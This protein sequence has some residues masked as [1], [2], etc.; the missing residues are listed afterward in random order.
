MKVHYLEIVTHDV[1]GQCAALEAAS[2]KP[3]SEPVASLGNARIAPLAPNG[4]VGVRAPMSEEEQPTIRPYVLTSDIEAALKAAVSAGGEI[5]H[6]P[7]EIP[8]EGTFAIY[9]LDGNQHGL[10]Q[11]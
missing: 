11:L 9:F 8:G 7:L 10:W 6:P 1:D 5:A 4:R 2:G 3:F